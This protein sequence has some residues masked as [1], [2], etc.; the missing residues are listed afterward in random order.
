M[1]ELN[2]GGVVLVLFLMVAAIAYALFTAVSFYAESTPSTSTSLLRL[3]SGWANVGN[4]VTHVLL[5]VYTL[6]NGNNNSEYWIEERKLGGIEGP[7]FLAILNLAAGISSLLYNSMLFPLGWNSFVIAA[8]TF[9][10][11]V[12]PRFLAEG[13]AT[14]PYTIIFV[15]FLIFAFELTAFTCSVTHFALSAKGAKKNM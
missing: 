5:I 3:L 9:L 14:W 2:D 13:I 15:W 12:W 6:A 11:V 4:S 10:P 8:G 7:V 1:G